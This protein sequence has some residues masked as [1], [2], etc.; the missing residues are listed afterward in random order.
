MISLNSCID[1]IKFEYILI[2]LFKFK[3]IQEIEYGTEY[4]RGDIQEMKNEIL[5]LLLDESKGY[6]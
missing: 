6:S 2:Q 3:F 1:S 5:K 4:F